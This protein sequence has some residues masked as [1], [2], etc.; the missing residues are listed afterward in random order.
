MVCVI[1]G[2]GGNIGDTQTVF[3]NCLA[4]LA[5]EGRVVAVS[6]LWR[7]RAVGPPQNDFLNAAAVI[8]WPAGPHHLHARCQDFERA[9]GRK[10]SSEG[11]WGP[12]TLDLDLLLAEAL[13]CRGPSLEIPHLRF[14]TRRFALEPA[15]EVAPGWVH[16][17]LGK[18][19]SRLSEDARSRD[20]GAILE[21]FDF[22]FS[23]INS[24]G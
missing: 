17:L 20:P 3:A 12:R 19:V 7:T 13:V 8:D 15:A 21:T 2:L 9:A 23:M 11:L 5:A 6:R 16:P 22:D 10:R 24:Q 1:L 18:T 4:G 14:H